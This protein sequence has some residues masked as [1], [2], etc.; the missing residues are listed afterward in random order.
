[1]RYRI[2]Y[3]LLF[4]LEPLPDA[5]PGSITCL[6]IQLDRQGMSQKN[7]RRGNGLPRPPKRRTVD[8]RVGDQIFCDGNWRTILDV[9]AYRDNWLTDA[10]AANRKGD[11][12]YVYAVREQ[13]VEPAC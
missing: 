4:D 11:D 13:K 12:G 8:L 9:K 1:M 10:Q 6:I 7:G 5:W 2:I 3:S